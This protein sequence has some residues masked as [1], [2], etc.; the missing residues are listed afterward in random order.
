MNLIQHAEELNGANNTLR[1]I[2]EVKD[3]GNFD[4]NQR[5]QG[6][7]YWDTHK[8]IEKQMKRKAEVY[9]NYSRQLKSI[10]QRQRGVFNEIE[11]YESEMISQLTR[12]R[13]DP[14]HIRRAEKCNE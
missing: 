4:S 13:K 12:A 9:T 14:D 7:I 3:M 11:K 8:Q 6:K 1:K 2:A 10:N 5:N